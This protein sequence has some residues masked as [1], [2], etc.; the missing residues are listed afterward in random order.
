MSLWLVRYVIKPE[1]PVFPCLLMY[2]LLFL[3]VAIG[4]VQ[5]HTRSMSWLKHLVTSL[6]VVLAEDLRVRERNPYLK[7]VLILVRENPFP[8]Q[9]GRISMYLS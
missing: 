9:V 2:P 5:Y 4:P 6:R 1:N 8:F 7:C 3:S